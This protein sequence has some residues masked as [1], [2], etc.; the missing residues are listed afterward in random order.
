MVLFAVLL[1]PLLLNGLKIHR[2]EGAFLLAL[3]VGFILWQV[4]ETKG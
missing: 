2:W 1:L 4:A 3:Y